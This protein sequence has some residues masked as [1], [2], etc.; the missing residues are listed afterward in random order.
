[1]TAVNV[2]AGTRRHTLERSV[3]HPS[4]AHASLHVSDAD[5]RTPWNAEVRFELIG[6]V[7]VPVD[8]RKLEPRRHTRRAAFEPDL[9]VVVLGDAPL[10]AVAPGWFLDDAVRCPARAK[11]VV[12]AVHPV[13][14]RP[15]QEGLLP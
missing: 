12:G 8:D 15:R 10:A 1:M 5:G 7:E 9:A 3:R 4:G 13:V 2:V 6:D 11:R 14:Q